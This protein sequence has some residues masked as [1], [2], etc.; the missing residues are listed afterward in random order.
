MSA[1]SAESIHDPSASSTWSVAR[2]M[3]FKPVVVVVSLCNRLEHYEN[4]NNP[5][6]QT[7]YRTLHLWYLQP[8]AEETKRTCLL[9]RRDSTTSPG[10]VQMNSASRTQPNRLNFTGRVHFTCPSHDS[11]KVET[12][13]DSTRLFLPGLNWKLD[14]CGRLSGFFVTWTTWLWRK[15]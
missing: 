11:S 3:L 10:V 5:L 13:L 4:A 9:N 2:S 12:Q 7:P 1:R 6:Q 15:K 8:T 14:A